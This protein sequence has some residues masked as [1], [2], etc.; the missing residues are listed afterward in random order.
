MTKGVWTKKK[1][2]SGGPND[3]AEIVGG[4]GGANDHAEVVGGGGG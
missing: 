1:K 2:I 3:H 4:G